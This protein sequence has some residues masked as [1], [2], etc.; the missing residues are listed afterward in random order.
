MRYFTTGKDIDVL[1]SP[2]IFMGNKKGTKYE[3]IIYMAC[4]MMFMFSKLKKLNNPVQEEEKNKSSEDIVKEKVEKLNEKKEFELTQPVDL[5]KTSGL[6]KNATE[7]DKGGEGLDLLKEAEKENAE[8]EKKEKEK[9]ELR[10]EER[11]KKIQK[12]KKDNTEE[13]GKFDASDLVFV[14]LGTLKGGETGSS[15]YHLF[16]MTFDTNF[17][18]VDFWEPMNNKTYKLVDRVAQPDIL[19]DFFKG[20]FYILFIKL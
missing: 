1:Q 9:E 16:L 5:D 13:K 2:D 14:C 8:K 10:R 19:K 18:D 6:L 4:L 15:V 7:L 11:E 3:H 20:Y 12:L 17:K